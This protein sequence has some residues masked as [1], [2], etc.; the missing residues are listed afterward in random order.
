MNQGIVTERQLC[1]HLHPSQ[2][3][4]LRAQPPWSFAI[5]TTSIPTPQEPLGR[6][7]R[8]DR[9]QGGFRLEYGDTVEQLRSGNRA[10]DE[11]QAPAV[12]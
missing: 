4:E 11:P 8:L 12:W 9:V 2:L 1:E 6:P 7:V 10:G 5:L 3:A